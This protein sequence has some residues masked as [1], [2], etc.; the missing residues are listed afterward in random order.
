MLTDQE[1]FL[2]HTK[3]TGYVGPCIFLREDLREDLSC[4]D[5]LDYPPAFPRPTGPG[6]EMMAIVALEA[7]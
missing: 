2:D 4:Q 7:R 5:C 3:T 1:S 6:Y